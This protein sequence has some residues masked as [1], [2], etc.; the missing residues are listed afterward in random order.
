MRL[1]L[2]LYIIASLSSDFY[3]VLYLY[4]FVSPGPNTQQLSAGQG[5]SGDSL[6]LVQQIEK[7][8]SF[9]ATANTGL[10]RAENN[11]GGEDGEGV[12]GGE[13][14]ED[15]EGVEDGVGGEG[16]YWADVVLIGQNDN[17]E[18]LPLH[19]QSSRAQVSSRALQ[20]NKRKSWMEENLHFVQKLTDG[21][22]QV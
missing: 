21:E 8:K 7:I 12:Q 17:D 6:S 5:G 11:E 2:R 4:L 20:T 19:L 15:V 1:R 14:G 3:L 22:S 18:H 13:G 10:E 9:L 16:V